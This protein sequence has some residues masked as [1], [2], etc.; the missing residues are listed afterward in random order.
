VPERQQ[1]P[2]ASQLQQMQIRVP[3]GMRPGQQMRVSTNG[4][5]MQVCF[6]LDNYYRRNHRQ[7]LLT[8]S[9]RLPLSGCHP[10]QRI[11]RLHLHLPSSGSQQHTC[12]RW[13]Q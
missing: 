10:C 4:S 7:H 13:R 3:A 12:A 1:T 2:Q 8:P 5:L 11:S 9:P 6:K